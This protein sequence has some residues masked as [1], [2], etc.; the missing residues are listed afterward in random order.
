LAQSPPIKLPYGRQSIS[1]ADIKA[2]SD[3]LK[4]DWI[5]QGPRIETFEQA[6]ASQVSA[7]FG[8]AVSS[9]TAA[10]HSACLAAGLGEGDEAIVPTLTF[11]ATAAAVR[12]AG[13]EVR[14]ADIDSETL[15][16]SAESAAKCLS[17]ATKAILPVD[18]AGLPCDWTDLLELAASQDLITID[19]AA[20]ALGAT[21][22]GKPVGGIADM[23]CFSFH[24]VK[25][26]TTAEGG[27]ILANDA[28]F[29]QKLRSIRNHGIIR[30]SQYF[31]GENRKSSEGEPWYY[32]VQDVGLNYRI[33][34]IQ[35]ALGLSQLARLD[36]FVSK[37]RT[38]AARYS[39]AFGQSELIRPRP[40]FDD[41]S[42]AWHL[43]VIELNLDAL[44]C[45]RA[46]VFLALRERGLGVQVHYVPLHRHP[47]YQTRYGL[48]PEMF[49]NAEQYY[50]SA[51][52][53]PLF[54]EMTDS[55]ADY[56]I[57]SV[58]QTLGKSS[59]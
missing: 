12:L 52:S 9:G 48:T 8:V 6:V 39:D 30:D 24:P 19:D 17:E 32:E 47:Y 38:I 43:Y 50:Q 18:F 33:S 27:M 1:D 44:K 15:G 2:V 34:D 37:R 58:L 20:H 31:S 53:L 57:D 36:D 55:D 26:I 40:K 25:A 42:S 35:C 22:Q 4:G 13:A 49:P 29:N 41:R 56:V 14:I 5:T 54:P 21:Y 23:T 28:N 7:E 51:I 10:L 11:A 16:L 3:V 45:D 46:A 59:R